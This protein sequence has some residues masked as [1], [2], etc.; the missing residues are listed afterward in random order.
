MSARWPPQLPRLI[1]REQEVL[2]AL[3]GG[4]TNTAIADHLVVSE[5]T[6]K[7]HVERILRKFGVGS[8]HAVAAARQHGLV[9][10]R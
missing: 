1:R 7:T 4:C 2:Q 6:V 3:A 10:A 5:S 9:D 8:R